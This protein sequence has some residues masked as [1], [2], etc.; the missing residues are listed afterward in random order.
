M[1][2]L[3]PGYVLSRFNR[4]WLFAALWTA[5]CQAP[6]SVGF[7]RQEYW[8]GLPCPSSGHLPSSGT[9]PMPLMSPALARG[10]FTSSAAWEALVKR[11]D[12]GC[13]GSNSASAIYYLYN[14]RQAFWLLCASVFSPE[15]WRSRHLPL[16]VVVRFKCKVASVWCISYN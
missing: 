8:S 1:Y 7:S 16:S 4:V 3:E 6:L 12:P 5:D 11:E 10:F 2:A 9:E 13:L 15:N 14:L